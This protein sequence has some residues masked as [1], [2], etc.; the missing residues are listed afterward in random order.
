MNDQNSKKWYESKTIWFNIVMLVLQIVG[1]IMN[2]PLLADHM[3]VLE[4]L[5]TVQTLGNI[6]IRFLTD[7]PVAKSLI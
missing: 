1:Q 6:V 2:S 4:I 5:S 3:Q 7:S